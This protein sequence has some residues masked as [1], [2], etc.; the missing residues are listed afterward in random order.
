MKRRMS[1]MTAKYVFLHVTTV[2]ESGGN[3]L[4]FWPGE[5]RGHCSLVW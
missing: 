2:S 1:F 5:G 4:G 3:G